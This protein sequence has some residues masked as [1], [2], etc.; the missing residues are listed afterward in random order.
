MAARDLSPPEIKQCCA[1]AYDSDAAKLLLGDSFHPG[2]VR[3][4]GRLGQLLNLTPR[5]HVLDVAAGTGTSGIFLAK[6]FG[7]EVVGIDFSRQNVEEANRA[8][9]EMG[10][11]ERASF[12]WADAERL[13]FADGAFDAV[14]CECSFCLFPDKQIAANEFA[15]VLAAG[16]QVGLSDLTRMETLSRD[17]DGLMSWIACIADARPLTAYVAH[18]SAANLAIRIVEEHNQLLAEFVNGIRTRL[19]AAEIAAGLGKLVLP[20]FDLDAAKKLVRS[21]QEAIAQ[22]KLGYAIVTAIK[23]A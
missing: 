20:G 12:R 18:L 5:A 13:P 6:R 17:L 16:G 8:A 4:T 9:Q 7:C 22:G 19:L 1:A 14:I 3:L 15:R 21:A 11:A 10:L 23:P 2:G